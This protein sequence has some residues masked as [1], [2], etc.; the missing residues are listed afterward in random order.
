LP[1]GELAIVRRVGTRALCNLNLR[2]IGV[3]TDDVKADEDQRRDDG[4]IF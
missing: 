2:W 3:Y 1:K 4:Q